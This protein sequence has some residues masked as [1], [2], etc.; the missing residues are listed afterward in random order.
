MY[1][2]AM[3]DDRSLDWA[4]HFGNDREAGLPECFS[5]GDMSCLSPIDDEASGCIGGSVCPSCALWL[6]EHGTSSTSTATRGSTME[7]LKVGD[8]VASPGGWG[9][10]TRVVT[11]PSWSLVS[12]TVMLAR[13]AGLAG[14][15][16]STYTAAEMAAVA[17]R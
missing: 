6:S 11:T 12:V 15:A 5:C 8:E 14:Y 13:K 2:Y 9:T 17:S 1:D 3:E 7:D 10:V 16:G 4:D